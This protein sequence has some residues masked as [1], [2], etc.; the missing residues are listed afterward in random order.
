MERKQCLNTQSDNMTKKHYEAIADCIEYRLCAKDNHPHEIAKRLAD[1]FE[2][3]NKLFDRTRFLTA[4]G[5]VNTD[6]DKH[7]GATQHDCATNARLKD[8]DSRHYL[9]CHACGYTGR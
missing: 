1:F 8:R 5:I 7:P 9:G 2:S 3:D 4:C 6:D